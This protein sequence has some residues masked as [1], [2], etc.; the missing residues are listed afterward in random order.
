MIETTVL[1]TLKVIKTTIT[2]CYDIYNSIS[3]AFIDDL[4]SFLA[5]ISELE[6]ESAILALRESVH[7]RDERR[8]IEVAISH[9]R[10]AIEKTEAP[11]RKIEIASMIAICYKVLGENEL[12]NVY[13]DKA[14]LA[15][16]RWLDIDLIVLKSAKFGM[17]SSNPLVAGASGVIY[18]SKRSLALSKSLPVKSVEM[19]VSSIEEKMIQVGLDPYS[20]KES[21]SY[22]WVPNPYSGIHSSSMGDKD[23]RLILEAKK[24]FRKF[25]EEYFCT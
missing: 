7:S 6:C 18:F 13:K 20:I 17:E 25:M 10:L 15:F 11:L 14:V 2:T 21:C 24:T 16:E 22:D 4:S 8:E 3:E 9:L 1:T 19:L 23:E 5:R 12:M